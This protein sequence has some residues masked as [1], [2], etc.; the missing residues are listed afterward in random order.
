VS[1][2]AKPANAEAEITLIGPGFGESVVIHF[3]DNCWAII[4]CC[5]DSRTKSPAPLSYLQSIGVDPS[6]SVK[7][8]LA[9]HWHN[10]HIGGIAKLIE[11]C[12]SATFSFPIGFSEEQ[13]RK[14]VSTYHQK[15][16]AVDN[17]VSDI[18]GAF[19]HILHKSSKCELAIANRPI[20]AAKSVAGHSTRIT[21][22]SPSSGDC[23]NFLK[24]VASVIP[25][26]GSAVARAPRPDSN[27]MSAATWLEIGPL[28]ILLGADLEETGNPAT[29][30]TAV[31]GSTTRPQGAASLFKVPHHGSDNGHH[32]GVWSRM[33]TGQVLALVTPWNRGRGLPTKS[34]QARIVQLA[35]QSFITSARSGLAV[36]HGQTVARTLREANAKLSRTEQPTGFIRARA[37]ISS[38]P[39]S[40]TVHCSPEACPLQN[41]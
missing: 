38:G 19:N 25:P 32:S 3:G 10:D 29:G 35:P 18:C 9:T 34:D 11:T 15:S 8:V 40:W 14:F 6:E 37:P 1:D 4:D 13:F 2:A 33:L 31:L 41:Y 20:F 36:R 39:I 28:S 16:T 12:E 30:W 24:M 21:A 26:R 22:L 17:G 5:I 23:V 27:L 7:F